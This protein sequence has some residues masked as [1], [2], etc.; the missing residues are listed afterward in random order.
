MASVSAGDLLAVMSAGAYGYVM[1]S[2]YCSRPRA[3]E[4]MVKEGQ[5]H[6]VKA[7]ENYEDLIRGETL[8]P[9]LVD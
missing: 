2:N 6:I 1:S 8:P 4:V 3:A 5:F 7:R 9:F